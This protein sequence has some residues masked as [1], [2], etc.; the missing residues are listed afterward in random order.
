[1]IAV[2]LSD[3]I[4]APETPPDVLIR[5][6]SRPWKSLI[7]ASIQE[8]AENEITAWPYY[9]PTPLIDLPNLAA[10][11]G[12]GSL[13]CKD[14]SQRFGRGGVKALGAP[15]GLVALMRS[16]ESAVE[17]VAATDGNHG[18]ALAWEARRHNL[19]CRIFVS[20]D[21][22]SERLTRLSD[23]GAMIEVVSGTYDDAVQAASFYASARTDRLLVTDTDYD[24]DLPVTQAIMAGYCLLGR[25]ASRQ[26]SRPVTHVMLQCGVGGMAA[27]MICGF[28]ELCSD[29][30]GQVIVVEPRTADCVY[31][32]LKMGSS[33][34]VAGNL[35]TRML[36]LACGRMSQPAW[37]ILNAMATG[38]VRVGD[39]VAE[40]MQAALLAGAFGDP[41]LQSG[42]TGVAGIAALGELALSGQAKKFG[43]G[44]Y[45][46]V[47]VV[48]SEGPVV[49]PRRHSK[50]T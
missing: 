10:H 8:A 40:E 47:L 24:G 14:E 19:A 44:P 45:A 15:Y 17:A 26:I 18:L 25:E 21:L 49:V 2:S 46:H 50:A 3:L 30:T 23:Q 13:V 42:D 33:V 9:K 6:R 20:D 34:S 12:L 38:A 27:G 39:E 41:P 16:V 32:S 1:M 43:L 48:N 22:D 5:D 37:D 31:Q 11:L 7:S 29:F 28:S 36:G 35:R 4:S